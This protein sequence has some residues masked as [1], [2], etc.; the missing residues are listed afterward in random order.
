MRTAVLFVIVLVFLVAIFVR[1]SADPLAAVR[2]AYQSGDYS[3]VL[4]LLLPLAEKGH[5]RAQGM[6]GA[7][8]ANG[9]G[10]GQ[11]YAAA[12]EWSRRAA[13]QGDA[14]AQAQ[15][16]FMYASGSGVYGELGTHAAEWLPR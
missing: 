1:W 11:N 12:V 2:V 15:L 7:L 16:G 6:L 9:A 8:Y 5:P 14:V 4:R 10:V 3:T 13:D